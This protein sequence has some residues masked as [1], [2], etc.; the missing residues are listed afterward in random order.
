MVDGIEKSGGTA[1]PHKFEVDTTL[2]GFVE[3]YAA[4]PDGA[5]LEEV[6]VSVAGRVHLARGQASAPRAV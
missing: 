1:Y 2:P 4:L 5:R 6:V 3:L